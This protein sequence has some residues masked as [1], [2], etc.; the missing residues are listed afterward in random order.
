MGDGEAVRNPWEEALDDPEEALYTVGV[1][2]DLMGVDPQVVRGYDKRGLVRP[3]RSGSGQRRYS[4][5]DIERL[6]RAM[7]LADEGIPGVGIDRILALEDELARR[8]DR[9]EE[10]AEPGTEASRG[11]AEPDS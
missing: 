11:P 2:A 8:G 1:V 7:E 5:R 10:A 9:A 4:R 6:S 3:D